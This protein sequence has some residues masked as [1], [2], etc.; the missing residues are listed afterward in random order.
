M[1]SLRKQYKI[2]YVDLR[3]HH[4]GWRGGRGP[5]VFLV[6]DLDAFLLSRRIRK[7]SWDVTS[8]ELPA[9]VAMRLLQLSS[10]GLRGARRLYGLD[11][12]SE[13][14]VRKFIA[15]QVVRRTMIEVRKAVIR[16]PR[17]KGGRGEHDPLLRELQRIKLSLLADPKL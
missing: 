5:Y 4:Q 6:K 16:L 1:N 13:A 15:R 10:P 2:P 8:T 3:G 7:K 17:R 11:D 9:Q 14:A 12:Y